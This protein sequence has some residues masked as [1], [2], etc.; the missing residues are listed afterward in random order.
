MKANKTTLYFTIAFIWLLAVTGCGK[1]DSQIKQEKMHDQ[2][3]AACI[4]SGGV[5][6]GSWFNEMVLS[7]CIYKPVE[8]KE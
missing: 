3:W 8:N 2:A 5:P 4:N 6:T 7:D 1:S